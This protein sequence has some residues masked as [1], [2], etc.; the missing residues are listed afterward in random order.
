M[1]LLVQ[2]G[3]YA[4]LARAQEVGLNEPRSRKPSLSESLHLWVT[5]TFLNIK[6]GIEILE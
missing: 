2:G 5:V 1:E 3:L 6:K 4:S